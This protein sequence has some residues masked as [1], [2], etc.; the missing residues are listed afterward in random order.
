MNGAVIDKVGTREAVEGLLFGFEV[1]K[2]IIY[3]CELKEDNP[4]S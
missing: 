4:V 1:E 2:F 3:A